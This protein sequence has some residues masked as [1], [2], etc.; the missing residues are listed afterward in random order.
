MT[1]PSLR[2]V[3]YSAFLTSVIFWLLF[4]SSKIPPIQAVAPFANDPYDAVASFAFQIALA[5]ALLSIARLASIRDEQGLRQRA[6]FIMH[7]ILLVVACVVI[8]LVTDL[9]AMAQAWPWTWS[10]P[11][12]TLL[13]GLILLS[14]LTV[15]TGILLARAHRELGNILTVPASDVLA[16]AI[17][18][19]WTLV[20]VIATGV[21]L[22]VPFLK[23]FW[24]WIDSLAHRI[25][26]AWNE[27]LPFADP[28]TH[29]W[30]FALTFAVLLG[31]VVMGIILISERI[32]EGG[33]PN[34][35]IGFLLAGIFFGG[36]TIAILLSF[37]FLGG[38]LGLRP[39]IIKPSG[40]GR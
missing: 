21:V 15:I 30:I 3:T 39:Q 23:P 34:P 16:Q 36:E 9:S 20:A 28:S 14:L 26:A 11:V 37:L 19:C 7:G 1:S 10:T 6:T 8:T 24:N 22:H 12:V 17:G 2:T 5:I 25:A 31:F 27:R 40:A 35:M 29:P 32:K 38:Y 4:Q 33:P 13:A 18:D